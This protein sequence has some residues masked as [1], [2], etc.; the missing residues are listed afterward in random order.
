MSAMTDRGL[1]IVDGAPAC[2]FVAFDDDRDARATSPD[3]R[4][5]C[6]AEIRPAPRALA[7][8]EAYCLSSS[9]AVCPT[10]QDWARREAAKATAAQ[11]RPA[12]PV[13]VPGADPGPARPI[14]RRPTSTPRTTTCHVAT[15]PASGPRRRHG[16]GRTRTRTTGRR[17]G[18]RPRH[19]AI[20]G[21]PGAGCPGR[22]R[23]A[24]AGPEA[25]GADEPVWRDSP[26]GTVTEPTPS[27]YGGPRYEDL[28][29]RPSR[30][31]RGSRGAPVAAP[32]REMPNRRLP[33]PSGS[34]RGVARP[35]RRSRRG[36]V[37]AGSAMPSILIGLAAVVIAAVAL[38]FLPALLGIGNPAGDAGPDRERRRRPDRPARQSR[39]ARPRSRCRP[40]RS[41]SSSRTTR[42]RRSRTGSA[43]R[44]RR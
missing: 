22:S 42:C 24:C 35:T 20:A 4:H 6:Y 19:R 14:A 29:D 31:A 39:R 41:T 17:A 32:S 34:G 28:P 44:S 30:S 11:P 5:R 37:S 40:S 12:A 43:S 16:S 38:F 18:R 10:F 15:H 8:Q 3:H 27:A 36:W 13:V 9:F 23:T 21:R 2:P 1:P 26:P 33:G 7:H 25:A